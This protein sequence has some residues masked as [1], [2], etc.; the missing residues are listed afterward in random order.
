MIELYYYYVTVKTNHY[1]T[2]V[3]LEFRDNSN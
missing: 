1:V 2:A 3:T